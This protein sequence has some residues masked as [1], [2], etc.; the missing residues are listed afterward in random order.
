M[1]SALSSASESGLGEV[2]NSALCVDVGPKAK[3]GKPQGKYYDEDRYKIANMLKTMDQ[4]K[5]QD[6]SK[7]NVQPS[8]GRQ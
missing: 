5:Q 4:I 2:N 1:E 3:K 8:G 6:V 7:V